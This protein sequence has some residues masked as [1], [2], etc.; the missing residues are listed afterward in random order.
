MVDEEKK[1]KR[2]VKDPANRATVLRLYP[3]Q[4]QEILIGKT[5]GCRRKFW[6][7][8]H[9]DWKKRR[10]DEDYAPLTVKEIKQAHPY[11]YEIDAHALN[12][13]NNDYIQACKNRKNNPKHFGSPKHKHRLPGN[14]GSYKTMMV[15]NNI[16]VY[17]HSIK[18]PK[19][20]H[21]KYSGGK[22]PKNANIKNVTVIK[23]SV[24][25][26]Y[27]SVAYH[28]PEVEREDI[29]D[30]LTLQN[31][32]GLDYSSSEFF[33]NECGITPQ[34]LEG[35]RSLEKKLAHAQKT[36]SRRTKGSNRYEDQRRT[37]AR[38]QKKIANKRKDFHH[39]VALAIAKQC[40]LCGVEDLNLKGMSSRKGYK[41]GKFVHDNGFNT[42][43]HI[44]EYKMKDHGH[45]LI[46]VS[47]WFPS[48]NTCSCCGHRLEGDDK[49]TLDQRVFTCPECGAV[50]DRDRNA[51]VNIMREALCIYLE[52]RS[53]LFERFDDEERFASSMFA[54]SSDVA[55]VR[56][57]RGR[58]FAFDSSFASH[59]DMRDVIA[60][61]AGGMPVWSGWRADLLD[62]EGSSLASGC[63]SR[64]RKSCCAL[65][66]RVVSS[67]GI[68][69]Y[70][71]AHDVWN[72]RHAEC[73]GQQ[74]D[75]VE[76]GSVFR[77]GDD[78][79]NAAS[80]VEGLGQPNLKPRLNA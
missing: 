49:L 34:E 79:T 73:E 38:I 37:V 47:R 53:V 17:K 59:G 50:M 22:L 14:A 2:E 65:R 36:L 57:V 26:Y 13:T 76:A 40:V 54:G 5:I 78:P 70:A 60:F 1:K 44:L 39:K 7:V 32:T 16:A 80:T 68:D 8:L 12:Q 33:V 46:K 31:I 23:D 21:V 48:T 64:E 20:G 75:L 27:A 52:M 62:G 9:D 6:N 24:G 61:C 15:N 72:T 35:F 10:N 4:E 66:R 58:V 41:H 56:G 69:F 63:S 42:F 3:D 51:A 18:L 67:S 28:T 29:L 55:V 74:A 77:C 25:N 71:G 30:I 45:I 19:L 43:L 11:M